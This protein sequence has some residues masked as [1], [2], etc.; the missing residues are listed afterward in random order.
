MA[1]A[2]SCLTLWVYVSR[3]PL[4]F[5]PSIA[6]PG[7]SPD[8]KNQ[9]PVGEGRWASRLGLAPVLMELTANHG[10]AG[11]VPT[12]RVEAMIRTQLTGQLRAG[13]VE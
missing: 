8:P 12:K 13:W 5:D 2:R 10:H 7:L 1:V 9:A 6:I 11:S 3:F 4:S